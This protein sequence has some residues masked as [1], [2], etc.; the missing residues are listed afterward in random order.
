MPL[1]ETLSALGPLIGNLFNTGS[2]VMTNQQNR[3]FAMQMYN[4]QR[5][6]ALADWNR[7]NQYNSPAAQMQRY[8]EAGLSPHLIYGQTNVAPPVR[9]S[10]PDVPKAQAPQVDPSSLNAVAFALQIKQA[11]Q[12]LKNLEAQEQLTIANAKKTASETDWKNYYTGFFKATEQN[13]IDQL[14]WQG[15][16]TQAKYRTENQNTEIAAQK[17]KN[18]LE[19]L[20]Q[21][22]AQTNY[23][24]AQTQLSAEQKAQVSQLIE[25][26]KVTK[27]LLGYQVDSAK[28]ESETMNKI[29]ALG[30]GG[31]TAIQLLKLI[32]GK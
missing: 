9:S 26:L 18:M 13:R 21:T 29:R 6:D 4:M 14:Y 1:I 32:M 23:L 22:K 24:L 10:Q 2:Q 8:K 31:G 16:L 3:Q 12:N 7:Q 11:Q 17:R 5:A 28:F 27:E 25:N 30:V 20:Q 19:E 15:N